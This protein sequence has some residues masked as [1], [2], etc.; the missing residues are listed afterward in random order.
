MNAPQP[1]TE[2]N[3]LTTLRE[4]RGGEFIQELDDALSRVCAEVSERGKSGS[5]TIKLTVTAAGRSLEIADEIGAKAPKVVTPGTIFFRDRDGRLSR[6]DP[7][8]MAI[9]F[10]IERV[11]QPAA[12]PT[13]AVTSISS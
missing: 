11:E 10:T 5:I 7:R 4:L 2:L 1:P 3:C 13:P 8:Q 9:P 6:T 12:Q